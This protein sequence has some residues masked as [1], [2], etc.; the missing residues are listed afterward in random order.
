MAY[1]KV[2]AKNTDFNRKHH[3][4][5]E[6]VTVFVILQKNGFTYF[7]SQKTKKDRRYFSCPDEVFSKHFQ[8]TDE[9]FFAIIENADKLKY[10]SYP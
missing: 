9:E 1:N 8:L 10:E 2:V 6:D 4:T 3:F 7:A 5:N